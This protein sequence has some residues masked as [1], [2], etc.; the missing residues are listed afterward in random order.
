MIGVKK[1]INLADRELSV[2][3][4]SGTNYGS[5]QPVKPSL[6]SGQIFSKYWALDYKI[7][8]CVLTAVFLTNV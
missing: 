1:V 8:S 7:K 4:K 2:A 5:W 6:A 3:L